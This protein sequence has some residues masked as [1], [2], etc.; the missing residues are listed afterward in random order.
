[1]NVRED[2][3]VNEQMGTLELEDRDELQNKQPKFIMPEKYRQMFDVV[4]DEKKNGILIL[5]KVSPAH[6]SPR[7][8]IM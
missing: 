8:L 6:W 3:K 5:K 7:G 2:L 4:L 1:M